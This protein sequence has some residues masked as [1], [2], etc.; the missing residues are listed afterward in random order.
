MF[1]SFAGTAFLNFTYSLAD[2]KKGIFYYA[3]IVWWAAVSILGAVTS[4]IISGVFK[5]IYGT[6]YIPGAFYLIIFTC[7]VP[8]FVYAFLILYRH[9]KSLD[10]DYFKRKLVI[11]LCGSVLI[12]ST[13]VV[14]IVVLKII[15]KINLPEI[16]PVLICIQA[17]LG[18]FIIRAHDYIPISSDKLFYDLFFNLKTG[19][20]ILDRY[21]ILINI[22]K[23]AEKLLNLSGYQVIGKNID[24][25]LPGYDAKGGECEFN[26]MFKE[27][28]KIYFAEESFLNRASIESARL[29]L[30]S[31]ITECRSIKK[32]HELYKKRYESFFESPSYMIHILDKG[33]NIVDVNTSWL[34]VLGYSDKKEIFSMPAKIFFT[35]DSNESAFTK[36]IPHLFKTGNI[37]V[38]PQKMIKKDGSLIDVLVSPIVMKD[39]DYSVSASIIIPFE[40]LLL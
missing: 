3:S 32:Q 25:I 24:K 28:E 26:M 1:G 5:S 31:D 30:L 33:G 11:V 40:N 8:Q 29:I 12:F 4:Q 35:K 14:F 13:A 37:N 18:V 17:F 15:L 22:N 19:I 23:H 10:D 9:L 27:G 21:D 36:I 6:S 7:F 16:P 39:G 34:K 2:K 20:I 38:I